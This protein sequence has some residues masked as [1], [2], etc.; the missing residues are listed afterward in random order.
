MYWKGSGFSSPRQSAVSSREVCSFTL[1]GQFE[2]SISTSVFSGAAISSGPR[3]EFKKGSAELL[4]EGQ[5]GRL[6][7]PTSVSYLVIYYFLFCIAGN[8]VCV[9]YP[10][11]FLSLQ[12]LQTLPYTL[13]CNPSNVLYPT[14]TTHVELLFSGSILELPICGQEHRVHLSLCCP[15]DP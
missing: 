7:S 15:S 6:H 10:S 14:H 3:H 2:I 9:F 11:S 8:Y 4:E 13:G 5:R 12:A 1:K